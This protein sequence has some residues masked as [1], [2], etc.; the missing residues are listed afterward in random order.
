MFVFFPDWRLLPIPLRRRGI[1]GPLQNALI[2]APLLSSWGNQL[3]QGPTGLYDIIL[4]SPFSVEK[5]AGGQIR[6]SLVCLFFWF[7]AKRT[8]LPI[9]EA[10]PSHLSNEELPIGAPN[11]GDKTAQSLT[12]AHPFQCQSFPRLSSVRG[13]AS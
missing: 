13:N 10:L 1:S 12:E 5:P 8:S 7:N 6:S 4:P 11:R 3:S 9:L 2:Q